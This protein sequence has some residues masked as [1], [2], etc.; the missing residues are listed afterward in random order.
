MKKT[1][2]KVASNST[3]NIYN[4]EDNEKLILVS[5]NRNYNQNRKP[6]YYLKK[7]LPN[8]KTQYL[9][10]LFPTKDESI[11]SGDIKHPITGMKQFFTIHFQNK[12]DILIIE[13]D[14]G[15]R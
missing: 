13:A 6:L 1:Y 4:S 9:T 15:K 11:F 14:N 5:V 2:K 7:G 12:G 8:Q 10:G 3:A